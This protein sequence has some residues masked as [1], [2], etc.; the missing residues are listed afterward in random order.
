MYWNKDIE[1]LDRDGLETM[2]LLLLRKT[3]EQ[4]GNSPYYQCTLSTGGY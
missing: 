2:Q 3:V 4:A 1:T